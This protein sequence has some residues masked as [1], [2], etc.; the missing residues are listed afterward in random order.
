MMPLVGFLPAT[1]PRISSTV[2]AIRRE[3]MMGDFVLRYRTT[4]GDVDGHPA[5]ELVFLT[6]S[7]WLAAVLVLAGQRGDARNVFQRLL[8]LGNN[9]GLLSA[10]YDPRTGQHF[11]NFPQA[12]TH[13]ALVGAGLA[14]GRQRPLCSVESSLDEPSSAD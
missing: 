8:A 5:G 9:V 4:D 7:F 13:L 11:G 1:D 2:D 12:F 6:R 3:L 10:E 14:P